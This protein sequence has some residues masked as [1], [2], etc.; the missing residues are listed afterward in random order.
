[1]IFRRI[2]RSLALQFTAFVFALLLA[3]GGIFIAGDAARRGHDASARLDRQLQQVLARPVGSRGIPDLP[4]FE[5]E[6]VR[7]TDTLGR[8]IYA[9]SLFQDVPFSPKRGFTRVDAGRESY[10][11]LT[12]PFV[13]DGEIVG[14]LQVADIAPEYALRTRLFLYL[15]VSA[16]ISAAAYGAGLFFARRS[17]KPA[18]QMMERLEQFTQDASHELRTPLTAVGTSLDLAI[19]DPQGSGKELRSAKKGLKDIA[20]LGERLLEL[21]R[22]DAFVLNRERVDMSSLV[23]NV[24]DTHADEAAA[25][26]VTIERT[27]A[28]GVAVEADPALARQVVANL[29]SNAIKFNAEGGTVAVTLSK[30]ALA[31]RDTGR[32]IAPEARAKIF[33]RFYREDAA[34][35][36]AADGLGLGLALAKRVC[37]LHG[38]T[39][40]V[41]SE[42]G[43]GSTFTVGF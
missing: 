4:P 26:G 18:E 12:A 1:M 23:A 32:G 15:L 6:R 17:L 43:K 36:N 11:V 28:E 27:L 3:A 20:T 5:R 9:G 33:D 39:V 25:K 14:Y 35:S 40:S 10:D 22:L 2:S 29:V 16:A 34:R 21:A 37:D 41:E 42:E 8:T 31:V 7:I 13:E 30:D 38:W 19:A 24:L